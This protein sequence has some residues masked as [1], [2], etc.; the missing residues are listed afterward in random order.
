MT[1]AIPYLS[2]RAPAAALTYIKALPGNRADAGRAADG[3]EKAVEERLASIRFYGA[4]GD[5]FGREVRIALPAGGWT[6][7]E[8]RR[9]LSARHPDAAVDPLDARLRACVAD[10]IVDDAR[11][12]ADGEVVEFFPPLSGG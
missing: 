3:A 1:D 11:R 12:V 7:G 2:G 5:A 4:A 9:V 8:I 6:I 10:T